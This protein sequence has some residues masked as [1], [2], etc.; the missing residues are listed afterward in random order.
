MRA[1]LDAHRIIITTVGDVH[2]IAVS[3]S[4]LR[5]RDPIGVRPSWDTG[6]A[7]AAWLSHV[8]Q[9]EAAAEAMGRAS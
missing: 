1:A 2:D 4:C 3:C 6:E 8:E 5:G 9:A 7:H